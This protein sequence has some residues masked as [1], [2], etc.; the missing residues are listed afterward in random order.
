M[1]MRKIL[2]AIVAIALL[3]CSG[4]V[5]FAEEPTRL[6]ILFSTSYTFPEGEDENNN[7][8]IRAIEAATNTDI[9]VVYVPSGDL[10]SKVTTIIASGEKYDLLKLSGQSAESMNTMS[11]LIASGAVQPLN[12]AIDKVAPEIYDMLNP[13]VLSKIS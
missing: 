13:D 7:D 11:R 5:S 12:D 3:F 1:G 8:Y 10:I 6:R 2:S 9:D 4:T